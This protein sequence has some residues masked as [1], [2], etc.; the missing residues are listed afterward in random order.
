[1]SLH[2]KRTCFHASICMHG[3]TKDGGNSLRCV[4]VCLLYFINIM[5]DTSVSYWTRNLV[6]SWQEP[7]YVACLGRDV[8]GNGHDNQSSNPV[9]GGLCFTCT[10]SLRKDINPFFLTLS[11]G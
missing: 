1:M 10:T 6:W 4:S 9:R 5:N 11:Y 2:K 7:P 8:M 3:R